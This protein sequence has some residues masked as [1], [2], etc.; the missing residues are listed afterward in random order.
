MLVIGMLL[1]SAR[2]FRN[3]ASFRENLSLLT[4]FIIAFLVAIRSVLKT[5]LGLY[6]FYLL[7]LSLICYFI[8]F[9]R[10]FGDLLARHIKG[11]NGLFRTLLIIFFLFLIIPY[12]YLSSTLYAQKSLKVMTD[13]GDISCWKDSRTGAFWNTVIYLQ[14]NTA[15]DDNVV[16]FP[17]GASINFFA[18]R[19]NP[20]KYYHFLPFD[21]ERIGEDKIISQ[22]I[23][24]RIKYVVID[25]R[26]TYEYGYPWFGVHYGKKLLSW[27]YDNYDIVKEF[28][29]RPFTG[30]KE[31]GVVILKKR[32]NN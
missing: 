21:L 29:P 14:K 7:D 23:D 6:G 32:I 9:F 31:F 2:I 5:E 22:L 30:A 27:I 18:D 25:D 8:F 17:E 10:V 28:G 3:R 12:W 11:L 20:L 15:R 26:A 19:E 13:R 16:V 4:L 24:R 1:F